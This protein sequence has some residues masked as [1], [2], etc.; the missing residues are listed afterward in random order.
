YPREV[1]AFHA[2]IWRRRARVCW[3]DMLG[4]TSTHL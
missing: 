2:L 3:R 4:F 1:H